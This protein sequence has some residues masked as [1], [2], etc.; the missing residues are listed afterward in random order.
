[1]KYMLALLLMITPAVADELKLK[2]GKTVEWVDLHDAGDSYDVTTPQGTKLTV[3]KDEVESLIPKKPAEIL[4]GATF[5][6]DK[7]RKLETVDLM[8][9]VDTK[10]GAVAGTWKLNGGALT[11][12]AG[13][14][15]AKIQTS[16]TPP[17]EYDLSM[18]IL[19]KE[20]SSDI[21]I[22]LIGG[23]KQVAYIF[24][25][26][27]GAWNGLYMVGGQE[28]GASGL[29]VQG[30]AFTAGTPRTVTFMVR[31]EALVVRLDG[32][33]YS[34]WKADWNTVSLSGN[35]SVP[36]KNVLFFIGY[37][38]SFQIS[39]VVLTTPKVQQ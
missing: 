6:F 12:T 24:D 20:G 35:H 28:A 1:M 11:C 37:S 4:T 38:G 18:E 19:R 27:Q 10:Q 17:E 25:A 13:A 22:G 23:G 36:A 33:D 9:Y 32:K 15:H 14:A 26:Y 31:K 5:A 39:K 21:G 34:T 7:K 30:K 29:G 16:Y 2:S 3:K 8:K